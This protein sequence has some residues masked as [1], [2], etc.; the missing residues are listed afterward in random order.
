MKNS[1]GNI[2]PLIKIEDLINSNS[3]IYLISLS[4]FKKKYYY[5]IKHSHRINY[6]QLLLI[7]KTGG[8]LWID[9][10]KYELKEKS[11]YSVAKGQILKFDL[12]NEQDGFIIIFSDEFIYKN[13]SDLDW[14][15]TLKIFNYYENNSEIL[16][17]DAAYLELLSLYNKMQNEFS[18]Q[19]ETLRDGLLNNL[20]KAFLVISERNQTI[21]SPSRRKRKNS[22]VQ[23]LLSFKKILEDHFKESRSVNFYA[24]T[25]NITTK[26]LNRV[27]T[28]SFGKSTKKIIEDRIL[29]ESK[30]LLVHTNHTVKEIGSSLGFTDPTNFNKFFKKYQ[31]I[32]PVNFRLE[33]TTN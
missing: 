19:F 8:N 21:I 33:Q 32:T 22:D 15:N 13:P 26:K 28:N 5:L 17:T 23:Y 4:E 18:T 30:R 10:V 31:N 3:F 14:V 11:I 29:L 12:V 24:D 2:I 16:L 6:F 9:S 1:N 20:L 25:M 7:N 27:I